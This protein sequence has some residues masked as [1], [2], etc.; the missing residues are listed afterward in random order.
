MDRIGVAIGC[1]VC[2]VSIVKSSCNFFKFEVRDRVG[3]NMF[4]SS[5]SALHMTFDQPDPF[6]ISSFRYSKGRRACCR[7]E[8]LSKRVEGPGMSELGIGTTSAVNLSLHPYSHW[9]MR[10]PGLKGRP[11]TMG[12][13]ARPHRRS[14]AWSE[15]SQSS[16]DLCWK[17]SA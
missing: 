6:A 13:I 1:G 14:T 15:E 5:S 16:T 9:G 8:G 7:S 10:K 17:A 11:R 4:T 3:S 2:M 12:R